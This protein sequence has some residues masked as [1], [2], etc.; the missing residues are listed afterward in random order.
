MPKQRFRYSP[1]IKLELRSQTHHL[2]CPGSQP[3]PKQRLRSPNSR[4]EKKK[5]PG[6]TRRKG[7]K[8]LRT[9]QSGSVHPACICIIERK[10]SNSRIPVTGFADRALDSLSLFLRDCMAAMASRVP[11]KCAFMSRVPVNGRSAVE[12][13]ATDKTRFA[14]D[15]SP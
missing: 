6:T 4:S 1:F 9:S 13:F 3:D 14:M 7:K 15:H 5:S 11:V 2:V 12:G 8:V 10:I